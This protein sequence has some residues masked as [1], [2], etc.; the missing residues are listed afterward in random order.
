MEIIDGHVHIGRRHLPLEQVEGVLDRAGADRA[1]VF[2][3]PES[4]D[5]P[6]DNRY[7]LESAARSRH[8]PFIYIGGNA[9]S[10]N[11]PFPQLPDPEELEPY[12]GI[13]WHCWFTPGHDF[14]GIRLGMDGGRIEEVLT[15]P[16]MAALMGKAREMGIPVNFEEHFDI[17]VRFVDLYPDVMIIIP[18]MGG[19]N[20]GTERIL[21]AVGSK[22]NV[23][24][25]VSLAGLTESL[26]KTF[27]ARKF[28]CGSDYPYGSPAWSID[29]IRKLNISEEDRESIM[30][31]NVLSLTGT[32]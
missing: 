25:D 30:S 16:R 3:D 29:R 22:P 8:I 26:V 10:T 32:T 28:I 18:H 15:E 23:F 12:R 9:Y 6:G 5:I 27:G 14:G 19:L 7:V 31:G 21:S 2:A 17:T 20:G 1:V 13:K 24:F 11:R 4:M